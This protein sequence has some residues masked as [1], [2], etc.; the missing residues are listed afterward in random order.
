M[1]GNK[2]KL[3]AGSGLLI[4]YIALL[5]FFS[6][7]S[8]YFLSSGNLINILN[9]VAVLGVVAIVMTMVIISGGIDLSV[10]SVVALTGVI[11]VKLSAD[12]APMWLAVLGGLGVGVVFGLINGYLVTY[13]KINSLITTLGTMSIARGLAFVFSGGLT[14]SISDSSFGLIGRGFLHLFGLDIPI[15]LVIMIVLF[16]VAFFILKY[17]IF[18]RN[19]YAIGG[20]AEASRLAGIKVQKNQMYIYILSGLSASLGGLILTSQLSAGAPQAASGL[21][22]SVIAAVILGGCS[23]LGGKGTM[24]GTFLGVIILGTMNNGLTIMN[25]SS[26]WQD[27][28]RGFI[29]LVAVAMDQ[30]RFQS[31][32]KFLRAINTGDNRLPPRH[33]NSQTPGK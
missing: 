24:I 31:L 14:S 32:T 13:L 7:N 17:S 30:F 18:G 10:A 16:I 26:Y 22:L 9:N 28:A 8:E 27:V 19:V 21:E 15:P 5:V 33:E 4:L 29:L 11:V 20:N 3:P 23:L 2:W 6:L 12:G 1:M 25:V